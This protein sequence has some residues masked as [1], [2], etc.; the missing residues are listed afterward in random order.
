MLSNREIIE[1]VLKPIV[2]VYSKELIISYL[3]VVLA[4]KTPRTNS[5]VY[6][7]LALPSYTH[8]TQK[9]GM[10]TVRLAETIIP[11]AAIHFRGAKAAKRAEEKLNFRRE[12]GVRI[13][14]RPERTARLGHPFLRSIAACHL[15]G[16][17]KKVP[18]PGA[19]VERD[20][21][22]TGDG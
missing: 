15:Q 1:R 17:S 11:D 13:N 5:E 7:Q 18:A 21:E 4:K 14:C 12:G 6:R 19:R 8:S 2:T 20:R 9:E 10:F 16:A 3:P 22:E